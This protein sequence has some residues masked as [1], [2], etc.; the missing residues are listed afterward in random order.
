MC[1]SAEDKQ[2]D[3]AVESGPG[4]VGSMFAALHSGSN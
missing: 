4:Y 3:S 1:R 2:K